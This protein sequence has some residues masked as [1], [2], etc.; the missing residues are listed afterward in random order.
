MAHRGGGVNVGVEPRWLLARR[1]QAEKELVRVGIPDAGNEE[2]KYSDA[3][4][5]LTQT[6][7]GD[8]EAVAALASEL[9]LPEA[10]QVLVF[11]GGVFRRD[12]SRFADVPRGVSVDPLS[13]ALDT[14]APSVGAH[15]GAL[16][17][18]GRTFFA[19]NRERWSDGL[20]LKI[21]QDATLPG[22]IQII[23]IGSGSSFLRHLVLAGSGSCA[24]ILEVRATTEGTPATVQSVLEADLDAGARVHYASLQAGG[25]QLRSWAGL[26]AK[27]GRGAEFTSRQFLVSGEVV[28]SETFVELAG[29]GAH[30]DLSGLS[31][32]SGERSADV[33]TV[34]RH[35]SGQATSHQ[36]FQALAGG[37]STATFLGIVKVD[38]DAQKTSARQSS[39]NLLLSREA[40]INS[41]PQLEIWAD[42]VKCSHGSTTGRLDEKALFFL[43]SRG[44]SEAGAKALLVRAFAGE[45]V[46]KLPEGAFR[47]RV[48]GLLE[49]VL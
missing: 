33:L 8:P 19:A 6:K 43:R 37:R 34:V 17:P 15:L 26:A 4:R 20:F 44:F 22:P 10:W 25:D 21:P 49:K 18:T 12:L 27:V 31:A 30:A 42:D 3:R 46:E 41:R 1:D 7:V 38:P 47:S 40:S 13:Q 16:D 11:V 2:W 45:L 48:E 29:P 23:D 24:E 36:L 39:R 14:D 35:A 5:F 32:V 28:R 9:S